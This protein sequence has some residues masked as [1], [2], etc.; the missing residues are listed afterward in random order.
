MLTQATL[1]FLLDLSNNNNR[2]WFQANKKRYE[3]EVKK[4]IEAF[5]LELIQAIQA[6]DPEIQVEPKDVLFRIYR[7][8]RFSNDKTPYKT[9]VGGLISKH[10]RR[11]KEHPG[12]YFHL[13]G[14]SLM[15]GGGAYF[16]EKDSLLK[17]RRAIAADP[18]SFKKLVSDPAFVSKFGLVK[19]EE[20]KRIPPEFKEAHAV[21]PLIAKKQF[22]YMNEFSP[23]NALGK[24]GVA[25]CAETFQCGKKL[26]DY[27]ISA[28]L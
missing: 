3:S 10:G 19:G 22:Y 12:Y 5:T 11:G 18:E 7:D 23:E 15:L 4:P 25:F 14:G 1:D 20:H 8:T 13:E 24:G 9:H 21:Q 28:L 16:L 2:D 17:L 6:F 27:L 26:N